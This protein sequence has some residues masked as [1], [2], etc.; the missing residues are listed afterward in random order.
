MHELF[1]NRGTT[2]SDSSSI[3]HLHN[4]WIL[5][6]KFTT[7]SNDFKARSTKSGQSLS[8]IYIWA[9]DPEKVK[10]ILILEL[11]STTKA[12]N[13]GSKVEGMIAQV[14]R[15][16]QDFYKNPTRTLNWD[17]DTDELQYIG[18]IL[19]RKSDI[20][21]ELT[22]LSSGA[23]KYNPIPFLRDSFYLDDTFPK[24]DN[25]RNRMNI[26]IEMYSYEDIYELAS[27]RNK[28]FFRL[29]QNEFG[30]EEENSNE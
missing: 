13:A 27:G 7:F 29:L 8:D 19:A 10:Q 25:P 24:D 9:D 17:V 23:G 12:H 4:L 22:S 28:V 5:D 30:F 6:D 15:Y 3:N 21:K 20:N 18:I 1:I 11:K 14:K 16:A 2:L 26:R